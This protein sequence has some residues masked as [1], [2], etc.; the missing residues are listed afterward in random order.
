M[1]PENRKVSGNLCSSYRISLRVQGNLTDFDNWIEEPRSR[2][3]AA[4]P[5]PVEQLYGAGQREE[6]PSFFREGRANF[7]LES[8]IL[9]QNERWRRA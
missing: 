1:I 3:R 2:A 8:L 6:F 5:E 7:Q 9:A 4:R